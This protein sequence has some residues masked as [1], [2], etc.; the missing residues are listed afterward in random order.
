MFHFGIFG[1]DENETAAF[2]FV[3]AAS[4]NMQEHKELK[5]VRLFQRDDFRFC[6]AVAA[7]PMDVLHGFS[8][9]WAQLLMYVDTEEVFESDARKSSVDS[10]I[11]SYHPRVGWGEH[12]LDEVKS[13]WESR[14]YFINWE[15][16]YPQ[17]SRVSVPIERDT[18]AEWVSPV[19]LEL[20]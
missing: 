16:K 10:M 6:F 1:K 2:A 3:A 19:P 14:G 11:G 7:D 4:R 17:K 8:V 13:R 18:W 5:Y 20:K 15:Q 9:S 12:E